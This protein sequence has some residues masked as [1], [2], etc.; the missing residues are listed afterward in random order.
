MFHFASNRQC[1]DCILGA[2]AS[3]RWVDGAEEEM[4][5]IVRER[6]PP[7]SI[8]LAHLFL[9]QHGLHAVAG[10]TARLL[11][12]QIGVGRHDG[13]HLGHAL[14]RAPVRVHVQLVVARVAAGRT[15]LAHH[16][17]ALHVKER[18]AVGAALEVHQIIEVVESALRRG[19]G[20]HG[21]VLDADEGRDDL[22]EH[23]RV[24]ERRLL[25]DHD[26]GAASS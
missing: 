26:V 11:V 21:R 6:V 13:V 20:Q 19:D 18:V 9:G 22:V 24:H 2:A 7:P 5:R 10:Q 16:A 25:Q 23:V 4:R 8:K 14:R 15:R 17:Q 1:A 3:A 12:A